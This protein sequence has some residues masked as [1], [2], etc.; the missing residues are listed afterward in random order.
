[1]MGDLGDG[2]EDSR[3]EWLRD[4]VCSSLSVS[5]DTFQY[6][7]DKLETRRAI[8][9]FLDH[10]SCRLINFYLL[11]EARV[12]SYGTLGMAG[13]GKIKCTSELP[14]QIVCEEGC[15]VYLKEKPHRLSYHDPATHVIMMQLK[16]GTLKHLSNLAR[17]ALFPLLMTPQN[18]KGL[19]NAAV[20]DF[21]YSTEEFVNFVEVM[22]GKI[23]GKVVLPLPTSIHIGD[24]N[25][26]AKTRSSIR[27]LEFSVLSW[28]KQI[29]W[30][31]MK[32]PKNL[33]QESFDYWPSQELSFW[34]NRA[35]ELR[36]ILLQL[37]SS[38]SRKVTEALRLSKST[39]CEVLNRAVQDVNQ[40]C[41]EA[42]S[43]ASYLETMREYLCVMEDNS[44]P[45][46][47]SGH[48]QGVHDTMSHPFGDHTLNIQ[49]VFDA[50]VTAA[51]REQTW[52]D[53][54]RPTM[55]V[56]YLISKNSPFY[57]SAHR[58][59]F[60]VRLLENLTIH[61]AR[62]H[63][64]QDGGNDIFIDRY[65]AVSVRLQAAVEGCLALK[66]I[67]H[68]YELCSQ[69]EC[70]Q[71][72]REG[73]W[74]RPPTGMFASLD[75]FIERCQDILYVVKSV[76]T[77]TVFKSIVIGGANGHTLTARAQSLYGDI[78]SCMEHLID[79]D[80]CLLTVEQRTS[81]EHDYVRFCNALKTLQMRCLSIVQL[82]YEDCSTLE[83]VSYLL[84]CLG[85]VVHLDTFRQL[86]HKM[87]TRAVDY[88][89]AQ[90]RESRDIFIVQQ[91]MS[92]PLIMNDN[93]P[94]ATGKL[95]WAK[96]LLK[97]LL[98]ADD[99]LHSL[100]SLLTGLQVDG[101]QEA[102]VEAAKLKDAINKFKAVTFSS[103]MKKLE[104]QPEQ[105]LNTPLL[106]SVSP[107]PNRYHTES[108]LS[109]MQYTH[110]RINFEPTVLEHSREAK[111]LRQ[112][113]YDLPESALYLLERS[114]KMRGY[115]EHLKLIVNEYNN[116][117]AMTHEPEWP[118][119]VNT[120]ESLQEYLH[121]ACTVITWQSNRVGTVIVNMKCE[122][123]TV[124][125]TMDNLIGNRQQIMSIL[126]D[127]GELPLFRRKKTQS[128]SLSAFDQV[129]S[130]HIEARCT[131][132]KAGAVRI[133]ALTESSM[134]LCRADW[135]VPFWLQYVEHI[136]GICKEWLK[137]FV[138]QSLSRVLDELK[139]STSD[140][141]V[142]EVQ[143]EMSAD[144][145]LL[146]ITIELMHGTVV[147]FVPPFQTANTSIKSVE[148]SLFAW[149][150][151]IMAAAA[152]ATHDSQ[153][154]DYL[155]H[156]SADREVVTVKEQ[157]SDYFDKTKRAWSDYKDAFKEYEFLWLEGSQSDFENTVRTNFMATNDGLPD[158]MAVGERVRHVLE[159]RERLA[160]Y[161]D[162]ERHGWVRVDARPLKAAIATQISISL[163][164]HMSFLQD[165]F[166][167][168]LD[169][170]HDTI[171]LTKIE[172]TRANDLRTGNEYMLPLI[173]RCVVRS[174]KENRDQIE[175][176]MEC[177][178]IIRIFLLR[179][180][181]HVDDVRVTQLGEVFQM[182]TDLQKFSLQVKDK[183]MPLM[184][185]EIDRLRNRAKNLESE[186][187]AV[188][189]RFSSS[190]VWFPS[191]S[192]DIA[193]VALHEM[194]V[195]HCRL[196]SNQ[197]E[198][199]ELES[200]LELSKPMLDCMPLITECFLQI[201]AAKN[202]WDMNDLVLETSL[203]WRSI[204]WSQVCFDDI[205]TVAQEWMLRLPRVAWKG[206]ENVGNMMMH[207]VTTSKLY[208]KI[209]QEIQFL[210]ESLP[211]AALLHHPALRL[212]HF[213]KLMSMSGKAFAFDDRMTLSNILDLG[214]PTFADDIHTL[215]SSAEK[216]L[217]NEESLT[218][219]QGRW[220]D[221]KMIL[222]KHTETE[223]DILSVE[224][225]RIVSSLLEIEVEV[226]LI[227]RGRF[228]QAFIASA[229]ELQQ[230]IAQAVEFIQSMM[231]AQSIWTT[232]SSLV[233]QH[234]TDIE[235]M[236]PHLKPNFAIADSDFRAAIN[237]ITSYQSLQD[238]TP[239][240]PDL[241]RTTT[242]L[243]NALTHCQKI[244]ES[245]LDQRRLLYPRFYLLSNDELI[246]VLSE[247]IQ[248]PRKLLVYLPHVFKSVHSLE[249][250]TAVH[251]SGNEVIAVINRLGETLSLPREVKFRPRETIV[252]D[253]F[254]ELEA[255]LKQSLKSSVLDGVRKIATSTIA[256]R[257]ATWA[258]LE[259]L[260]VV[261]L[262][263][264][265]Q[266]T[267][268]V[269]RALDIESF[270]ESM[271]ILEEL[272][273]T[274]RDN[275]DKMVHFLRDMTLEP[276]K[277]KKYS[278]L[279]SSETWAGEALEYIVTERKK[280]G[281]PQ[282]V[283]STHMF[284]WQMQMRY[285]LRHAESEEESSCRMRIAT[286]SLD[287]GFE[288]VDLKQPF[289]F[290]LTSLRTFIGFATVMQ[291]RMVVAL[292]CSPSASPCAGKTESF[293][294]MAISAGQGIHIFNS[295]SKVVY[296]VL[297]SR[298]LGLS[299]SGV[300]G[301]FENF[302]RSPVD[303]LS[304]T[305]SI[306]CSLFGVLRSTRNGDVEGVPVTPRSD[307]G[308]FMSF[309]AR[310]S[311]EKL[312][313]GLLLLLRP[314]SVIAPDLRA[315]AQLS[316]MA[317][318]FA[319]HDDLSKRL[320][321]HLQLCKHMLGSEETVGQSWSS[322]SNLCNIIRAAGVRKCENPDSDEYGILL[323]QINC[324]H[325]A[326]I[327]PDQ[328][329]M[330]KMISEEVLGVGRERVAALSNSQTPDS[331]EHYMYV[332]PVSPT[333][334]SSPHNQN[335]RSTRHR[336]ISTLEERGLR[337]ETIFVDK[338][339]QMYQIVAN[340]LSAYII[341]APGLG[342]TELWK[343]LGV[344][345]VNGSKVLVHT[346]NPNAVEIG[347]FLGSYDSGSMQWRRGAFSNL[348]FNTKRSNSTRG[349]PE[350]FH[351]IVLD[352]QVQP[353]WL[354]MLSSCVD[355]VQCLSLDSGE[356]LEF[357]PELRILIETCSLKHALPSAAARSAILYL[358]EEVLPL[359]ALSLSWTKHLPRD[360]VKSEIHRLMSQKLPLLLDFMAKSRAIEYFTPISP[361]SC[362]FSMLRILEG[363]ILAEG[364]NWTPS[365]RTE[366]CLWMLDLACIW[367]F[368]GP[369]AVDKVLDC[370]RVFSDWWRQT[371][372][373]KVGGQDLPIAGNVFD[374]TFNPVTFRICTW[375]DL[376]SPVKYFNQSHGE[377]IIVSSPGSVCLN[378]LMEVTTLAKHR[379]LVVGQVGIG[380]TCMVQE[381]LRGL[382]VN[383]VK[384]RIA[385]DRY[386]QARNIQ[387]Q[388]KQ[389]LHK[390]AGQVFGPEGDKTLMFFIDDMSAPQPN[391]YD[392]RCTSALLHQVIEHQTWFD[393][394]DLREC[395]VT[396]VQ[397]VSAMLTSLGVGSIDVRLLHKF[398]IIA[399]HEPNQHQI[400][401]IFTSVLAAFVHSFEPEVER[402][403]EIFGPLI[404]EV[405]IRLA[406]YFS[407]PQ[408][409][410]H[411][412]FSLHNF[413]SVLRSICSLNAELY[414]S[415]VMYLSFL[416]YELQR[417]YCDRLE[418]A[419][420]AH[421]FKEM[422]KECI[423]KYVDQIDLIEE[424]SIF[425]TAHIPD[426]N[427]GTIS[428]SSVSAKHWQEVI[429]D[430]LD[431]HNKVFPALD[432]VIWEH[433]VEHLLRIARVLKRDHGCLIL[434]GQGGSGRESL[435]RLASFC[436][437]VDFVAPNLN[438]SSPD[439]ASASLVHLQH[440][441]E[442]CLK[443]AGLSGRSI[444][445]FLKDNMITNSSL[446]IR[447][448]G[449]F[450]ENFE[451]VSND[452]VRPDHILFD[453]ETRASIFAEMRMF[454]Q[455]ADESASNTGNYEHLWQ[456]FMKRA[457]SK[458]HIIF[459]VEI[460][461]GIRGLSDFPILA[462]K[463][464]INV[465][466][467]CDHEGRVK[468]ASHKI[469]CIRFDPEDRANA[470]IK[471]SMVHA[472]CSVHDF[473]K[474]VGLEFANTRNRQYVVGISQ[475]IDLLNLFRGILDHSASLVDN[476][477]ERLELCMS[478][479]KALRLDAEQLIENRAKWDQEI[480]EA[481]VL[482]SDLVVVLGQKTSELDKINENIKVLE[483][484][485]KECSHNL[486]LTASELAE[487]RM[488]VTPGYKGACEDVK[489]LDR[490][491]LGEIKGFS[492]PPPAIEKV[493]SVAIMLSCP[494][495][496]AGTWDTSWPRAK[497]TLSS[498]DRFVMDLLSVDPETIEEDRIKAIKPYLED[499]DAF[500]VEI[501]ES[502]EVLRIVWDWVLWICEYNKVFREKI[503][504][505]EHESSGLQ[506][507]LD[508]ANRQMS[509]AVNEAKQFD[510]EITMLSGKVEQAASKKSKL[511]NQAKNGAQRYEN[512][513]AL[514][515][516][517]QSDEPFWKKECDE[518]MQ[519]K[520]HMLGD[521]LIAATLV[522]YSGALSQS[523]RYEL[524]AKCEN[525]FKE[526]NI[527][528]QSAKEPENILL[529][530][531]QDFQWYDEGLPISNFGKRIAQTLQN[532]VI[533][534][535]SPRCSLFLD[536]DSIAL[537]WL[538]SA[539]EYG[540]K[541]ST[542]SIRV[543]SSGPGFLERITACITAGTPVL[544]TILPQNHDPLICSLLQ[545]RVQKK[546]KERYLQVGADSVQLDEGFKL[547]L[548]SS[549]D[550]CTFPPA[551]TG[552][553]CIINFSMDTEDF[554]DSVLALVVE[555]NEQ[556]VKQSRKVTLSAF[557]RGSLQVANDKTAVIDT[558]L[559]MTGTL[560]S[561]EVEKVSS[562]K[563]RV[564]SCRGQLQSTEDK[565]EAM[566]KV[567]HRYA[568]FARWILSVRENIKNLWRLKE[569]NTPT[570]HQMLC[571]LST[572]LCEM[573]LG[574][575]GQTA[576]PVTT[577][578]SQPGEG[579]ARTG[580]SRQGMTHPTE[581]R[582]DDHEL[583]L[584]MELLASECMAAMSLFS[585]HGIAQ[586]HQAAFLVHSFFHGHVVMGHLDK[587]I[588]TCLLN[589]SLSQVQ[590]IESIA[591][592]IDIEPLG[593]LVLTL[594]QIVTSNSVAAPNS[595]VNAHL[596]SW[597]ESETP[598]QKK[599]PLETL[600]DFDGSQMTQIDTLQT[601][602][603]LWV[604]RPDRLHIAV[605]TE[606]KRQVRS[607]R[608]VE[609]SLIGVQHVL[610]FHN[611]LLHDTQLPPRL[612]YR[613]PVPVLLLGLDDLETWYDVLGVGIDMHVLAPKQPTL[614]LSARD[615]NFETQ[616]LD[617]AQSDAWM[618]VKDVD[619]D[620][621]VLIFFDR[622]LDV[623]ANQSVSSAR[624]DHDQD[625]ES[626]VFVSSLVRTPHE[627]FRLFIAV[628]CSNLY[629]LTSLR[630]KSIILNCV[631]A[632]VSIQTSY[633]RLSK[634][635]LRGRSEVDSDELSKMLR[636]AFIFHLVLNRL[637][638][639]GIFSWRFPYVFE[640][641]DI[642]FAKERI[643][644]IL[645]AD[646][647]TADIL[648]PD[649]AFHVHLI[650][651][652]L[653]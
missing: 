490:V 570:S 517:L 334:P 305:A 370:K 329:M 611:S 80:Y 176:K 472:M 31:V 20:A 197:L 131:V 396:N 589:P 485:V 22:D 464:S 40:A 568:E 542:R 407:A 71:T 284:E 637:S 483:A 423:H 94:N 399:M 198:I 620:E 173:L 11:E 41:S 160:T 35:A 328:Q 510:E 157:I 365:S 140:Q 649:S 554:E 623:L 516:S 37:E 272:R 142:L 153:V 286:A 223:Q 415:P 395:E 211:L 597:L 366:K 458:L 453:S 577:Q 206:E 225:D 243:V 16:G 23:E 327:L 362:C 642:S 226:N 425:G 515:C 89:C 625:H 18:R 104:S 341:G 259:S 269:E 386:S 344:M 519:K 607:L 13:M 520:K 256:H 569:F 505:L 500:G 610:Q 403:A 148:T 200:L 69:Q 113:G 393:V 121:E 136:R 617:S 409:P 337:A 262:S 237:R 322:I 167:K 30:S 238:M 165:Y 126:D 316:L 170:I 213:K 239:I 514:I 55:H 628:N 14:Q 17:H 599:F 221:Q 103:W 487:A 375:K 204:P 155:P 397:Y 312:P 2:K 477:I 454:D 434:L 380:K 436:C 232:L 161:P 544:C 523:F 631:Q 622:W 299:Q 202:L 537:N 313:Q 652:E 598:E 512:A 159:L 127:W 90:V 600:Q 70:G 66:N 227:L 4:T 440:Q 151:S 270:Q 435:V 99:C 406:E 567:A 497:R 245:W 212:R 150:D 606:L 353:E 138:I 106:V 222:S 339:E 506:E 593:R 513:K 444:T 12:D 420:E 640:S 9:Q 615:H 194:H 565:M 632:P 118:L 83:S 260:Q 105:S 230:Y 392:V 526:L 268:L 450:Q 585:S 629:T 355:S 220:A 384:S 443:I 419:S 164:R 575:H 462:Q 456:T 381:F 546:G 609:N 195:E 253:W 536:P 382:P 145:A 331:W 47:S 110:V 465:M 348:V 508:E 56:L 50:E 583:A 356:E 427:S 613:W 428:P 503:V 308:L 627:R 635:I 400:A 21:T 457:T 558:I 294:E 32:E 401:S 336:M 91:T 77:F 184:A 319:N 644:E 133:H 614:V 638:V 172:I 320:C 192:S 257:L 326:I 533:S 447:I 258:V 473:A 288:L 324:F 53:F 146:E 64:L 185:A 19:T 54:L 219:L 147:E 528:I 509:T 158:L 373:G 372:G 646:K 102:C 502:S 573:A 285:Y 241:Q 273:G 645:L 354:E 561:K 604:L 411:Y 279:A 418:K 351:W 647:V 44:V 531:G 114:E 141:Q 76:S 449:L 579:S 333:G 111:Y 584:K 338:M 527:P 357:G 137:N 605:L 421:M 548:R 482:V 553:S 177:L 330:L 249:F 280:K 171:I 651:Q 240:M 246:K 303:L 459:C 65:S 534:S 521:C 626:E 62:A 643:V 479:L 38:T 292:G 335:E 551:I 437:N 572:Q 59:G 391:A 267:G 248:T 498:A 578:T 209:E 582:F 325:G 218:Q 72:L 591:R 562:F 404:A 501:Q 289:C 254:K 467:P 199:H 529:Q 234:A 26:L 530:S 88:Y 364:D 349:T 576:D 653:H 504:P 78:H 296:R 359:E 475:H 34:A 278:I 455:D 277:R 431:E 499:A 616:F 163:D 564:D 426:F 293:K 116:L 84:I 302:D 422:L 474:H 493:M 495:S 82:A 417:E 469:G 67:Y 476:K 360:S 250:A 603:L 123:G 340:C 125:D 332:K 478:K 154:L 33:Q 282:H 547:M 496:K 96:I 283:R 317:Q 242:A 571:V 566:R 448:N 261:L 51:G 231:H 152:F 463:C 363:L 374:Y 541:Q 139:R 451:Y 402:I 588:F 247:G 57:N 442:S 216:E 636:R 134:L 376:V 263:F 117:F 612:K 60:F 550:T 178:E 98:A 181:S 383:F 408:Y 323:D 175:A 619:L 488:S 545:M 5:A 190:A 36:T 445:F 255:G 228:G 28:T 307:F 100:R 298:V 3:L 217:R 182:W 543:L 405:H 205:L 438:A 634:R 601:M 183:Y 468:I 68:K 452:A 276:L 207:F 602:L 367:G 309:G 7:L 29:R 532:S 210:L 432:M 143:D 107:A 414:T 8:S 385:L 120:L 119:V 124:I 275:L 287:Y 368:G 540:Q 52:Q 433:I 87:L 424:T 371:F 112:L 215:V 318:G 470:A 236:F 507:D 75:D 494:M 203:F 388:M 189:E 233:H 300:W 10:G 201:F 489:L 252:E 97:R 480:K 633:Q 314:V 390:K 358:S 556:E 266:W 592:H 430:Q 461:T 169:H 122:L 174:I 108:L 412:H 85:E 369:L 86:V 135:T 639:G 214:L 347:L 193:Y 525:R 460:R 6:L 618:L 342:K 224:M 81:F 48:R 345:G 24:E 25:V 389:R 149:C 156:I 92:K 310:T 101:Y 79:V 168:A 586:E 39:Y 274:C 49:R 594:S 595:T 180:G 208:C 552:T 596:H 361:R 281:S 63:I 590:K 466:A 58:V 304:Y 315:L 574:V 46:S 413:G 290:S 398:C 115:L 377:K 271:K 587:R 346:M 492:T 229:L 650:S 387:L 265:V 297:S 188:K 191:E 518:M 416:V 343:S 15:V 235:N 61:R 511:Q 486:N 410:E 264:K 130:T 641:G 251:S 109:A 446:L 538:L 144:M 43:N 557:V 321:T 560:D 128:Y 306:L 311:P 379:I 549:C 439:N 45:F 132:I 608:D 244:V 196:L 563:L 291:Q 535:H 179:H 429:S 73:A 74:T 166:C 630:N 491:L 162:F 555:A 580:E 441:L 129:H 93:L 481:D 95:T 522:A 524:F 27:L 559:S 394:E 471:Y 484:R 539:S 648:C 42:Q 1:M 187:L 352:G 378:R 301:L 621:H 295:N 624:Y 186:C 581:S 350:D